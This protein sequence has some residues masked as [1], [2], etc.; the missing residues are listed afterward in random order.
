[1]FWPFTNP[2]WQHFNSNSMLNFYEIPQATMATGNLGH[3]WSFGVLKNIGDTGG[4]KSSELQ[5]MNMAILR[6]FTYCL[7]FLFISIWL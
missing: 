7:F 6:V 5:W 4:L 3:L 2:P 1:M